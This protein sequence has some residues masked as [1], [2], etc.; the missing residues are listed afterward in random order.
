MQPGH[1]TAAPYPHSAA[2]SQHRHRA[3]AVTA[4]CPARSQHRYTAHAVTAECPAGVGRVLGDEMMRRCDDS[5]LHTVGTGQGKGWGRDCFRSPLRVPSMHA[6]G[7]P[8]M[9]VVDLLMDPDE[10]EAVG[11]EPLEV[12]GERGVARGKVPWSGPRMH[13]S[14]RMDESCRMPPPSRE[15]GTPSDH[16]APASQSAAG[17]CMAAWA[18]RTRMYPSHCACVIAQRS[19]VTAH[20]HSN[21]HST[22]SQPQHTATAHSYSTALESRVS[23][24]PRFPNDESE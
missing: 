9:Y 4:E 7:L 16:K 20:R 22:P 6:W 1:S 23:P 19:R 3:H 10:V 14:C 15:L 5:G 17:E 12:R 11:L 18:P 13:A 21:S 2:R 8:S 24:N